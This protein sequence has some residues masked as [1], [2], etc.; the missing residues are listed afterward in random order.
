MRYLPLIFL[1]SCSSVT[2][3]SAPSAKI[4]CTVQVAPVGRVACTD[5]DGKS[6][7]WDSAQP[8]TLQG[9]CRPCADGTCAQ[10]PVP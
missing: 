2:M 1:A 10:C 8:L 7:V 5:T 6:F 4:A 9:V 3:Q